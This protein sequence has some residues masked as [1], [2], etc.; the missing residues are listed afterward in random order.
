MRHAS[1]RKGWIE[2]RTEVRRQVGVLHAVM[3][4]LR[5]GHEGVAGRLTW[6]RLTERIDR[7]V[8]CG[9]CVCIG[10][11]LV[12]VWAL[13]EFVHEGCRW[14]AELG[15]FEGTSHDLFARRIK[16]LIKMMMILAEGLVQH[17]K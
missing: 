2:K 13:I 14:G 7:R 10:A 4:V 11:V 9:S 5:S 15:R 12:D 1:E 16:S 17:S 8:S 6:W 3:G